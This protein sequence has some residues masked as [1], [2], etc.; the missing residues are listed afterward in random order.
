[1]EDRKGNR[2]VT[3]AIRVRTKGAIIMARDVEEFDGVLNRKN[4]GKEF[5][6]DHLFP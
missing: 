4:Q 2:S 1:M 3:T 5:L 6:S